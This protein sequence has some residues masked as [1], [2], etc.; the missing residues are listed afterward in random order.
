MT[1]P[2]QTRDVLADPLVKVG[3]L[4][5]WRE[6]SPG[7]TGG[8][9]EGGFIVL[10]EDRLR[11]HRWPVGLGDQIG[12]PPHPGCN[13]EGCEVVATFH[14]HPNTGPE[15]L[16]EPS[17]SDRR[18]VRDDPDLKGTLYVGEFVIADAMIYLVTPGGMVRDIGRRSELLG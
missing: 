2:L 13:W 8:H 16:Q 5:A 3:M 18:G 15:Y 1:F 14:T 10:Q 7:A 17:E 12:V 6:S 11:V 9:E 4:Q